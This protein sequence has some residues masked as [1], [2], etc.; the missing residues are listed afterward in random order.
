M[1]KSTRILLVLAVTVTWWVTRRRY[2]QQIEHMRQQTERRLRVTA[3][4]LRDS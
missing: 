1:P 3:K 2:E 4:A